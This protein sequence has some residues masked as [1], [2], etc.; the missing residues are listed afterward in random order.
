MTGLEL[1]AQQMPRID[2]M[3]WVM[4]ASRVLHILGAIILV[5]GLF[6]LR[7]VVSPASAPPGAAPADQHFGGRRATWAKW[8]GI[9]TLLLL[10]TGFWNYF[11]Y[12]KTYELASSYHMMAGLKM[13]A[14]IAL[15]FVA[16]LVAGRS[17]AAETLRGKMRF[18]LNVCL[19]LGLITVV[20]GSVLRSYPHV[21][22]IDDAGPPQLIAPTNTPE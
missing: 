5:G 16:A 9:A 17:A 7:T 22:K 2:G 19:L 13:L 10:V 18:W 20:F 6:Y 4:L 8:I 1:L 21:E 12:I 14:G 3:Y 11:R 15:F